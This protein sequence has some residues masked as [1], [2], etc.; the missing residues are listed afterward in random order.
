LRPVPATE[1]K[2][3][4]GL[5]SIMVIVVVVAISVVVVVVVVA[6]EVVLAGLRSCSHLDSYYDPRN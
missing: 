3:R 2:R 5:M 1:R 4:E 6:G